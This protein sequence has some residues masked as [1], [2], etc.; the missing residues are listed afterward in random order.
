VIRLRKKLIVVALMVAITLPLIAYA[1]IEIDKGGVSGRD[2]KNQETT[3]NVTKF[4]AVVNGMRNLDIFVCVDISDGLTEK[5]AELIVGTTFIQVMGE[6]VWHRLV[7]L[8]FD[9]TQVN[10]LYS[11]GIDETD[12]G[13][14]CNIDANLITLNI[15]VNHC[16]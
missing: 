6:F 4:D 7:T 14:V 9:N 5:E 3:S 2:V 15:S 10:A 13:H 11:W 12:L 16:F 8:T 1:Y